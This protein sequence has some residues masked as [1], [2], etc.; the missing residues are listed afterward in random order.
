MKKVIPDV[1]PAETEPS[2]EIDFDDDGVEMLKPS[3]MAA[4]LTKASFNKPKPS[5]KLSGLTLTT[6]GNDAQPLEISPSYVI[7]KHQ[8]LSL[9]TSGLLSDQIQSQSH[10]QVKPF[11]A[12]QTFQLLQNGQQ[13]DADQ[14][15]DQLKNY[16][17]QN[18]GIIPKLSLHSS[19]LITTDPESSSNA[20]TSFSLRPH[21]HHIS[22]V[23]SSLPTV[24][25][26]QQTNPQQMSNPLT[27]LSHRTASVEKPNKLSMHLTN[28]AFNS[29][30][31]QSPTFAA[32]QLPIY[33]HNR[34]TMVG[35]V[36]GRHD[37]PPKTT[38]TSTTT[39]TTTT[40]TTPPP[41]TERMNLPG[42]AETL[43][44]DTDE[45]TDD[46]I[47]KL[48]S[49]DTVPKWITPSP[50]SSTENQDSRESEE[51]QAMLENLNKTYLNDN[52]KSKTRYKN[53]KKKKPQVK[54][55]SSTVRNSSSKRNKGKKKGND[56]SSDESTETE[57][58]V[59]KHAGPYSGS[60]TV[61]KSPLHGSGPHGGAYPYLPGAGMNPN[62]FPG[63]PYWRM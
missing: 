7:I 23:P 42:M 58:I 15:T 27:A 59:I 21:T 46:T 5:L 11:N 43:T 6:D 16:I 50:S 17:R 51:E 45:I 40:T 57:R 38:S 19:G 1:Q 56:S 24:A 33:S 14:I 3:A 25:F 22:N 36:P 37:F 30:L 63:Y 60:P 28:S 52:G 53:P 49:Q 61:Y 26:P 54:E 8:P 62:V 47:D 13:I 41:P 2:G 4:L 29:R 34:P 44:L 55:N 18:G 12:L 10:Q 35:A 39:S 32:Y 31:P 48:S 9:H 20:H